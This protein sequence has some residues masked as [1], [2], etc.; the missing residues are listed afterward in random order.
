MPISCEVHIREYRSGNIVTCSYP[1]PLREVPEPSTQA[2]SRTLRGT[3][4][5]TSVL[6]DPIGKG[7]ARLHVVEYVDR[8]VEII[9]SRSCATLAIGS[10][11][12]G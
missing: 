9:S 1:L 4:D 11:A 10:S 2:L 8:I 6:A 5:D 3:R 7:G 12:T